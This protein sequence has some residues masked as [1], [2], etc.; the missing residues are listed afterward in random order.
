MSEQHTVILKETHDGDLY[1]DIPDDVLNR[2]D[3]K[4]GDDLKFI[5][6]GD[7]FM[8]KKVKYET[9]ELEFE[10]EQLL[11]YMTMAHERN[12]TFNQLCEDA[13]KTKL[14]QLDT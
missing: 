10:S 8:I 14:D 3:W 4:Q 13:I 9:V 7:G 5:E 12:I 6:H 2:L 11:S 1:F